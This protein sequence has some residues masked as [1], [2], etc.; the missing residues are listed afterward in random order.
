MNPKFK[1]DF[2]AF[3]NYTYHYSLFNA[4]IRILKNHELSFIFWGRQKEYSKNKAVKRIIGAVM[5]L[6]RRKY[7]L[8]MNFD[9]I[10]EGIRLIHP[11]NITI[12][13]NAII[14]KRVTLFKGCT[15]GEIQ[16]GNKKGNPKLGNNI[17][18]FANAT[19]CGDVTIGDNSTIAANSFVNF[20][21]PPNSTVLGNPGIIHNKV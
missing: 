18:V 17:T 8:E 12:N 4:A 6:Y 3:G 14:G 2:E 1:K 13:H 9:N 7:G 11:W 21:V 10:G 20:D 5:F 16:F 19:I 15:I